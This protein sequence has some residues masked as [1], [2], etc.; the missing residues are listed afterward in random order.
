MPP[1]YPPGTKLN[2]AGNRRGMS[3]GS[4]KSQFKPRAVVEKTPE[5]ARTPQT[6]AQA[7]KFR[8]SVPKPKKADITR[9]SKVRTQE[10]PHR[11]VQKMIDDV[12]EMPGKSIRKSLLGMAQRMQASPKE[13]LRIR[14]ASEKELEKAYKENQYLFES[15]WDYPIYAGEERSETLEEILLLAGA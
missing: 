14:D 10:M 15:Y 6:R 2:K 8:A 11:K 9:V 4:K 1:A 5:R 7:K 3:A 13:L 12:Y